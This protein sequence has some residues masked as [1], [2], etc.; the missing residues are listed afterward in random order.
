MKAR[1]KRVVEKECNQVG[2]SSASEWIFALFFNQSLPT[3][4]AEGCFYVSCFMRIPY[5]PMMIDTDKKKEQKGQIIKSRQH[6]HRHNQID[7]GFDVVT[8]SAMI[9]I[10]ANKFLY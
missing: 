5:I 2:K 3:K 10:N 4:C 7:G 8:S 9:T 1:N 6:R